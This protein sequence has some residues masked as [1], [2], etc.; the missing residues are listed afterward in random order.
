[1]TSPNFFR[2]LEKQ[3]PILISIFNFW[4]GINFEQTNWVWWIIHVALQWLCVRAWERDSEGGGVWVKPDRHDGAHETGLFRQR[5]VFVHAGDA[6]WS[7]GVCRSG[8]GT[9]PSCPQFGSLKEGNGT[10]KRRNGRVQER[11]KSF[12]RRGR[13]SFNLKIINAVNSSGVQRYARPPRQDFH[14]ETIATVFIHK[15]AGASQIW[16]EQEQC[17]SVFYQR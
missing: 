3:H 8:S 14:M 5:R 13:Q 16:A 1:M 17:C 6:K 12:F 11:V 9:V 15:P 2:N 10:E 7:S 4:C